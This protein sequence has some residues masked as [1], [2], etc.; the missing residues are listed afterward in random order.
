[1][2]RE[3]FLYDRFFYYTL[4]IGLAIVLHAFGLMIDLVVLL[5]L[6]TF[7]RTS[8]I[9]RYLIENDSRFLFL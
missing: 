6:N 7:V 3:D 5:S 1:M 8:D 9:I 2:K 4:F